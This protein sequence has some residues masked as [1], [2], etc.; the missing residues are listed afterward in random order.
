MKNDIKFFTCDICNQGFYD[1]QLPEDS[2]VVCP[3]CL[4]EYRKKKEIAQE[5]KAGD[6]NVD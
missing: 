5:V 6:I 3:D 4:H 1:R 2:D